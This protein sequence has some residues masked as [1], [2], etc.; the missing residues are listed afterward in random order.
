[1]RPRNANLDLIRFAT[2]AYRY[3]RSERSPV[4]A[5]ERQTQTSVLL[6]L[7]L[8]PK[9]PVSVAPCQADDPI[10]LFMPRRDRVPLD[11]AIVTPRRSHR[12]G[13]AVSL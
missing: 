5:E 12:I 4:C 8:S 6:L 1:M 3:V 2:P 13:A 11:R 7:P 9:I 10:G